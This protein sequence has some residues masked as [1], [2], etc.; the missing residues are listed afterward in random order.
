MNITQNKKKKIAYVS[1]TRADFGLMV[2][3][4]RAI[5]KS[6]KL[7]LQMYATGVHLMPEFGKTINEVRKEFP[8]AV[9]VDAVFKT[10]E[11]S[12]MAKFTGDFLQKI[13]AVFQKNRPDFV[14]TLGDRPEMLCVAVAC[15][16][17]GIPTG[18]IHGGEKSSTIDE[19]ARHAITK[20]SSIHFPATVESARRIEKM[21]EDKWRIR[22]VGA[23]ALDVIFNEKLPTRKE[24]YKFLDLNP[25]DRII[26]LTQHPVSEEY[27]KAG[28]Q[29]KE[30]IAAVKTFNMPVVI[31][32]PHP[33]AGGRR[34]IEII[35]KENNN[36]LFRII[37]NLGYKRFLALERE[38]AVWI[39]N[40]SGAM[41]ESSSFGIPVVNVGTRQRGR[42]HG[43]NVINTGYNSREITTAI[44]KSLND[45]KYLKK[46]SKI[47]NPYGDGKTGARIARILENL[48][49]NKKLLIKQ[50]TY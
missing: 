40:S 4:L 43:D 15:L 8:E 28:E 36:P 19:L 30:S 16:Y 29:M 2:P 18:Q 25:K 33:D 5:Y 47:K 31:T 12:G 10:D 11:R 49:L 7:G 42:Q 32:Y 50:I 26:L 22:V 35:K 23:P 21:G 44:N 48:E 38:A 41:I 13:I 37:S 1:G 46:L 17:L 39:G 24:L 14:L 34:I 27:K 6:E 20:L 45:R 3:I 9:A